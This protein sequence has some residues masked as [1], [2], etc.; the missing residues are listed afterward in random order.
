MNATTARTTRVMM[1]YPKRS[2]CTPLQ[3]LFEKSLYKDSPQKQGS[4]NGEIFITMHH[5]H[6]I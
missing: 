4:Y 1:P 2:T 3:N 6:H 5:T